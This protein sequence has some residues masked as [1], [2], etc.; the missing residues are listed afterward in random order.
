MVTL[1]EEVR[2]ALGTGTH[3]AGAASYADRPSRVAYK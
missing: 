1:L 3:L 2:D